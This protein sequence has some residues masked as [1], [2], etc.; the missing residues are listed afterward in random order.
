MAEDLKL[1]PFLRSFENVNVRLDVG[2]ELFPFQFFG[3]DAIVKL[4][5][6]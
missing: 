2:G 4:G 3:D 6:N 5:F 1:L